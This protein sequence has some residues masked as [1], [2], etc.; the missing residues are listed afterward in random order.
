L[1]NEKKILILTY[2]WY[3]SGGAGVQRI[4][5]FVKYLPQFGIKP[6]IITVREDK[7]SYPSFDYSF[8][9]DIPG[10]AVVFRTGTNEPFNIY[11]R[12]LGKRSIPTGFS[13]ESSP[14][15]FQK[16]S[17]FVRG[18]LFIPDARKG[19]IKF[20]YEKGKEVIR[21]ENIQLVLSTSPPHSTQLAAMKLKK[22]LGIKWI[23]DLRDP[24]TDIY[25]Y[26]EF[27]HSSLAKKKDLGYERNVLENADKIITVSKPLKELFIKKSFKIDPGKISVIPNGF[28]T[29]DF[30][31]KAPV[32]TQNEFIIAYTGT[33]ADSYNPRVFFD[34]LKNVTGRIADIKLRIRFVG[35][36][37]SAIHLYIKKLGFEKYLE[38]IPAV[39][40]EDS[41]DYLL[42]STILLLV[43]P[44]VKN[45]KGILTGKLFE[46]LASGKPIICIGPK[47]GEAA[48]IISE[49]DAGKTFDRNDAEELSRFLETLILKWT[50]E[51]SLKAGNKNCNRFSRYE[52]AKELEKIINEV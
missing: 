20:A 3:P 44:E 51:K 6:F 25:F 37:S 32:E 48:E 40:H 31:N 43:I 46:Y 26:N 29:D 50:G 9:K 36:L 27:R 39:S 24:W 5:K 16:L 34:A 11:S 18:N 42:Q 52:Q 33:I 38:A 19:W 21:K 22:E 7:A 15:A 35:N 17:R 47:D 45:D 23:A 41:I 14:N 28:D 12:I 1:A 10:E 49:C 8:E 13:N 2:Y 4:L 30:K